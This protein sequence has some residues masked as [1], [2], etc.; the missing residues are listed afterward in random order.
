MM[1]SMDWAFISLANIAIIL[2][3]ANIYLTFYEKYCFVNFSGEN[4]V[5]LRQNI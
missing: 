3:I 5:I 1:P 4:V 2:E